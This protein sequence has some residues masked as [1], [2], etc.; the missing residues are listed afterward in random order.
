MGSALFLAAAVVVPA[1]IWRSLSGGGAEV[2]DYARKT[3]SLVGSLEWE[4]VVPMVVFVGLYSLLPHKE[5]RF[6]MY[7]VP[8][9]NAASAVAVTRTWAAAQRRM[10]KS[11]LRK[12]FGAALAVG[13]VGVLAAGVAA[14]GVFLRAANLNYP[15]GYA[16]ERLN[17]FLSGQADSFTTE[18]GFV[19]HVANLAAQSG[20]TRFSER[21]SFGEGLDREAGLSIRYEKTE[22]LNDPEQFADY[23]HLIAEVSGMIL[24]NEYFHELFAVG[25]ANRCIQVCACAR[26]PIFTKLFSRS[27]KNCHQKLCLRVSSATASA[28]NS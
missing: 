20:F 22:N 18:S 13:V 24:L 14:G 15:G 19:I 23:T 1:S 7:A 25:Q 9:L 21:A 3:Q 27:S 16:A 5:L 8:A 2:C 11:G 6:I 10:R 17:T 28:F 4:L 12:I 26:T